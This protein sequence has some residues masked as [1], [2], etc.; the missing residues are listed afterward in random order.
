MNG[1][2]FSAN[3]KVNEDAPQDDKK[4]LTSK[5]YADTLAQRLKG[6]TA[7]IEASGVQDKETAPPLPFSLVKL[8]QFMNKQH[9]MTAAKTLEITQQLR[10]KTRYQL[11]GNM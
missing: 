11:T 10:E 9:K 4:R 3:W 7:S 8:Q 5:G 2:P 1:Q 6:K